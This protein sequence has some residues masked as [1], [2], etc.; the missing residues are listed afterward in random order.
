MA[1]CEWAYADSQVNVSIFC[2]LSQWE[3]S[4]PDGSN[5]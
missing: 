5:D 1:K 3:D 2:I 4:K